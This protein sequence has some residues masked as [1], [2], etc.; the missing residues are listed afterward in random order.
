MQSRKKLV[1]RAHLEPRINFCTKWQELASIIIL[2]AL[3]SILIGVSCQQVDMYVFTESENCTQNQTEPETS[4]TFA[5]R[6]PLKWG[7]ISQMLDKSY[8]YPSQCPVTTGPI[9]HKSIEHIKKEN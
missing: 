8:F 1:K 2:G 3:L 6:A 5:S 7:L 9:W 4:S